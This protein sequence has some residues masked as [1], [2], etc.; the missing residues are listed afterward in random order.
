M[1]AA[2]VLDLSAGVNADA[3]L[4]YS[5]RDGGARDLIGQLCLYVSGRLC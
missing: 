1:M 5:A 2:V 3:N 4:K